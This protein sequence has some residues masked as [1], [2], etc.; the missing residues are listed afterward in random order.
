MNYPVY[1]WTPK[2]VYPEALLNNTLMDGPKNGGGGNR[3]RLF[4]TFVMS[5][6]SDEA[7]L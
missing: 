6:V 7:L 1:L 3:P 2:I 5:F 4:D